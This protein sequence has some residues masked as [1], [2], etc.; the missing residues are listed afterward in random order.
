MRHVRLIIT[1]KKSNTLYIFQVRVCS[2][3]GVNVVV[4]AL[5][6]RQTDRKAFTC[7]RKKHLKIA[8]VGIKFKNRQQEEEMVNTAE[9]T[10]LVSKIRVTVLL[11]T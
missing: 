9:F 2:L 7:W 6:L 10:P 8:N 1:V 4:R 3:T 5:Y 11:T